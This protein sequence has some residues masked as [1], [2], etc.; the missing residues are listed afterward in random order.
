MVDG[1]LVWRDG[2]AQSLDT[3]ILRPVSD[4]FDK[5]GG[6]RLVHGNL[7][8][9]VIKVSAVKPQ[10]RIVEAP[11]FVFD[12]QED[13]LAAFQAGQLD[14]G[15]VIVL[16]FQ[17]PKAN[18]MPELHSLS[19]LMSVLQDRGVPI[20]LVTDGRMS[21]ASGKTP[22]AIHVTPEALDG[23]PLAFVKTGDIVRLDAEA[24]VL[25]TSADLSSRSAAPATDVQSWGYGR[26]MFGAFRAAVSSAEEGASVC[27]QASSTPRQPELREV[28]DHNI[29]NQ[30]IDA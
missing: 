22:A 10:H 26:E 7:G 3:D 23:G 18:G 13:V 30:A 11:A 25:T 9:A 29:Q 19:P 21:G 6:L 8:R 24:G 5:E 17:G 2:V 16:R 27:F 4:P 15:G 20:A 28:A 12:S 14:Q 1:A